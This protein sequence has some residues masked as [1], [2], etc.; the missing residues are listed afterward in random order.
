MEEGKAYTMTIRRGDGI[1]CTVD[2]QGEF[3][4][5]PEPRIEEFKVKD[6]GAPAPVPEVEENDEK[7]NT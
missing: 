1:L 2:E 6:L 3:V 4:P 7:V 5:V